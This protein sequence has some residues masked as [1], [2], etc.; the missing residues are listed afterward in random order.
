MM[1]KM[2]KTTPEIKSIKIVIFVKTSVTISI[3]I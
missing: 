3:I 2:V 1:N